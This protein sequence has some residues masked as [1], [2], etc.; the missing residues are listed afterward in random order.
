MKTVAALAIAGFSLIAC[1]SAAQ[2]A[3]GSDKTPVTE[4][5]YG[6][7]LDIAKVVNVS[8]VPDVCGVVPAFMTYI[9]HQGVKHKLQYEVMGNGCSQS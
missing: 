9:D 6:T 2:A 5:T 4:Y 7:K 3:D 1:M 8:P